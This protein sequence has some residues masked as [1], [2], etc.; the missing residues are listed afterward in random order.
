M[1]LARR[2]FLATGALSVVL[3]GLV[4]QSAVA[5]VTD[6]PVIVRATLPDLT[7]LTD[8]PKECNEA[9]ARAYD[10]MKAGDF[11]GAAT[12]F[13]NYIDRADCKVAQ[14]DRQDASFAHYRA[15]GVQGALYSQAMFKCDEAIENSETCDLNNNYKH[16]LDLQKLPLPPLTEGIRKHTDRAIFLFESLH[17]FS[18][19]V[20]SFYFRLHLLRFYRVVQLTLHTNPEA[21]TEADA[22]TLWLDLWVAKEAISKTTRFVQSIPQMFEMLISTLAGGTPEKQTPPSLDDTQRFLRVHQ[23]KIRSFIQVVE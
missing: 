19:D 12:A 10:L 2:Y 18:G 15:A 9:R 17:E 20:E 6:F 8:V 11:E 16:E 22:E 21:L 14:R 7:P 13:E 5:Q 23:L 4:S 1:H 3:L